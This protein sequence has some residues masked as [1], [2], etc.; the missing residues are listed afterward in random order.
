[1]RFSLRL[2]S[3]GSSFLILLIIV[4][5]YVSVLRS[6]WGP[7]DVGSYLKAAADNYL[8]KTEAGNYEHWN[9]IVQDKVIVV[10]RLESEDTDWV[11]EYLP[12]SASKFLCL[13]LLAI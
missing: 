5:H 6:I 11:E 2:L 3:F 1:M 9:G 13:R 10:A 7:Y 8:R 4:I 12:E